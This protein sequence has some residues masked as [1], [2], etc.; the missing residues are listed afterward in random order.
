M[1]SP[2]ENANTAPM[3]GPTDL[4]MATAPSPRATHATWITPTFQT[5]P[6]QSVADGPPSPARR[7]YTTDRPP[8]GA[9]EHA[10]HEATEIT[11]RRDP[12]WAGFRASRVRV[13]AQTVVLSSAPMSTT[14]RISGEPRLPGDLL[15]T[16]QIGIRLAENRDVF[17]EPGSELPEDE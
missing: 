6:S 15:G 4:S 3:A 7:R 5:T 1:L 8:Q 17:G 13:V 2:N 12:I 10:T 16:D 14:A 9:E 11:T